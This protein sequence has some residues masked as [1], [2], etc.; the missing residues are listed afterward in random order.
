MRLQIK[1]NRQ[2]CKCALDNAWPLLA[3]SF[4]TLLTNKAWAIVVKL[5]Q[6][7]FAKS[8][9]RYNQRIFTYFITGSIR[10]QLTSC[11]ICFNSAALLMFS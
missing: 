7:T 10:L 8:R 4:N 1:S 6:Q 2:S 9:I 5:E 11:F 3:W